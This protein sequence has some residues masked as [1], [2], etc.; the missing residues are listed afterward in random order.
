MFPFLWIRDP[1]RYASC[2]LIFKFQIKFFWQNSIDKLLKLYSAERVPK[3]AVLFG[4]V[5][6]RPREAV[7]SRPAAKAKPAFYLLFS[8]MPKKD[9]F[10]TTVNAGLC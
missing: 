5:R 3:S 8:K 10:L 9:L 2:D 6:P 1:R 7:L 4:K